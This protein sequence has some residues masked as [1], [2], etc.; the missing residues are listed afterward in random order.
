M[1]TTQIKI[2]ALSAELEKKKA[3][4]EKYNHDIRKAMEENIKYKS[5]AEIRKN[6]V[7]ELEKNLEVLKNS[8]PNFDSE[9]YEKYLKYHEMK[10]YYERLVKDYK[11]ID[12]RIEKSAENITLYEDCIAETKMRIE[13]LKKALEKTKNNL[14]E[15]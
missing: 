7:A 1:T 4:I 13:Y 10:T 9:T 11:E 6:E 15:D 2:D 3:D 14:Q 8:I 12:N 5:G